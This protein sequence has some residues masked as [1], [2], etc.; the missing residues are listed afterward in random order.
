MSRSERSLHPEYRADIDGLR[1]LAVLS[2]VGFH[3]SPEIFTGGFVGVDVFFVISGFLISTIIFNSLSAAS[4]D[5]YGFYGRRIRRL[6]PALVVV[7]SASVIFGWFALLPSDYRELGKQVAGGAGFVANIVFWNEAGYFDEAAQYKPL[8]HLWSLG[9]EEQFYIL[10]PVLLWF[11]W[12]RRVSLFVLTI[13]VATASFYFNVEEMSDLA[14]AYYSPVTR[15]WELLLGCV[16]AYLSVRKERLRRRLRK[17]RYHPWLRHYAERLSN[18]RARERLAALQSVMGLLLILAIVFGFKAGE[19]YSPWFALAPTLGA[20]LLISAGPHGILN[21][22][23][24]SNRVAVWFGLISFPLYLWHWPLLAFAH[25]LEPAQS[26]GF[27]PPHISGTLAASLVS[28][29]IVLAWLTY[30]VVEKPVRNRARRGVVTPTL[31]LTM[32][33]VGGIG[34]FVFI[35]GGFPLRYPDRAWMN[36][37]GAQIFPDEWREHE[38]FLEPADNFAN[39][40]VQKGAGRLFFLWGD[41]QSASLYPGLKWLQQK[42]DIGVAQYGSA[43]CAPLMD[44]VKPDLPRC[45][46]LNRYIMGRI[47]ALRP[48]VVLLDAYWLLEKI[49]LYDL[50]KIENTVA[51]LRVLGIKRIILFGPAPKWNAPLPRLIWARYHAFRDYSVEVP[52]RMA[53]VFDPDIAEL[54]EKMEAMSKRLAIEYISI[55]KTLCNQAGCL[56]RVDDENNDLTFYDT[57]HL[58]PAGSRLLVRLVEDKLL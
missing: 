51:A 9:V 41:S 32:L 29:S 57:I 19:K 45:E 2:V 13:A 53:A 49:G 48:D 52:E 16:L 28:L 23:V 39:N 46:G 31:C 21:R 15:F 37:V 17:P 24:L 58:S 54:D 12:R 14:T 5:F 38:C 20:A 42:S 4:F 35:A 30:E 27:T 11:A 8:L 36:K 10:W 34:L 47:E 1:A 26:F 6:F 25:I 18:V 50:G 55:F 22:T 33:V 40:C 3:A 44:F 43:G 56:T 7:L